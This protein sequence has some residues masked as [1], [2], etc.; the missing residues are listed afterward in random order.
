MNR[1]IHQEDVAAGRTEVRTYGVDGSPEVLELVKDP[2]SPASAVAAQQPALIGQTA[3]RN[4]ARYLAG[5]KDLPKETYIAAI[6]A[7]KDNAAEVQKS[8]GQV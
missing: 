6:L 3:V 1:P 5:K 8:L 7:T 4:V 2:A